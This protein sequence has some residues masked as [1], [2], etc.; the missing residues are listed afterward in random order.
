LTPPAPGGKIRSNSDGGDL[1][2]APLLESP[3]WEW[4]A[5]VLGLIV[6]SFANVCIHRLPRHESVGYP[7]SRCPRCKARIRPWDNVPVLSYLILRG[8]CRGCRAPISARYPIVEAANGAA[9]FG[10]ATLM[11]PTPRTLVMMALV[12]ALLVLSLIDLEWQI[13]PNV[14]TLPGIVVGLLASFLPGPPSPLGALASAAGGYLAL[15]LVALTWKRLRKVEAL[16]QGDWKM[17]A[18]LGAFLGWQGMLLTVFLASLLGTL[19]GLALMAF[20]GR[21]S[22]H[23][24]PLGTFLGLA[25]IGVIF[26]GEPVLRWYQGLLGG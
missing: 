26:A 1:V 20:A 4:G 25:G 23:R 12:T 13:L 3:F 10:L 7:P 6:G 16:G 9:Y 14:I 17:A 5:F 19:V 21:S 2:T 8:R 15:M 24:L 22:Q 11:G 18:M